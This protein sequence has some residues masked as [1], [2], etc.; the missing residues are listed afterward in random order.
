MRCKFLLTVLIILLIAPLFPFV[1]GNGTVTD[2]EKPEEVKVINE[3]RN[4]EQQGEKDKKEPL[5]RDD[6]YWDRC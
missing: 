1:N 4:E 5:E 6:T 2:N 3:E